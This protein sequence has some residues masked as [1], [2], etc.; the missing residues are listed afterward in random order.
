MKNCECPLNQTETH[1]FISRLYWIFAKSTN[2]ISLILTYAENGRNLWNDID[3]FPSASFFDYLSDILG[4]IRHQWYVFFVKFCVSR[5]VFILTISAGQS[6][7]SDHSMRLHMYL[8]LLFSANVLDS[9][10][11]SRLYHS[12]FFFS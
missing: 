12:V 6:L 4:K 10:D 8:Q 1:E 2:E 3:V 11:S 9:L 7:A 5:P